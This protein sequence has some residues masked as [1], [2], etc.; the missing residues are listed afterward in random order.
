MVGQILGL[1]QSLLR[2]PKAAE[3]VLNPSQHFVRELHL[4]LI[5]RGGT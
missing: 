5:N 4:A 1:D 3:D 2:S